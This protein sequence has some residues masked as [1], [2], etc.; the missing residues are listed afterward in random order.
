MFRVNKWS[1][2]VWANM[3]R[4][5]NGSGG[6]EGREGGVL[7]PKTNAHESKGRT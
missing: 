1:F 5:S 7:G 3:G 2:A 6:R 4:F